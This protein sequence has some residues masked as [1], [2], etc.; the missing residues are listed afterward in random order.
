[1]ERTYKVRIFRP[2]LGSSSA[3]IGVVNDYTGAKPINNRFNSSFSDRYT[4]FLTKEGKTVCTNLS[5][6]SAEVTV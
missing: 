6:I 2:A 5:V 3:Y 4:Q 1:M